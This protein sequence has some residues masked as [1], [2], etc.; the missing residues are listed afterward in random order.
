MS[1]C[2]RV[3]LNRSCT[4]CWY[5]KMITLNNKIL[6]LNIDFIKNRLNTIVIST[7]KL[8]LVHTLTAWL[9]YHEN[10]W[11]AT[12]VD[13][14]PCV[15]TLCTLSSWSESV[16]VG[17]ADSYILLYIGTFNLDTRPIYCRRGSRGV[18]V[19][20]IVSMY[21]VGRETGDFSDKIGTLYQL[22]NT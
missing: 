17:N 18:I 10:F 4:Y 2:I 7:L 9:L 5:R 22:A 6:I 1:I 3:S 20:I 21:Y 19:C 15:H 13:R 8:T 12:G 14:K 16:G 11:N